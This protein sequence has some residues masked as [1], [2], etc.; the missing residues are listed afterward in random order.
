MAHRK[1]WVPFEEALHY[2]IN[3]LLQAHWLLTG[4]FCS[5]CCSSPHPFMFE[6]CYVCGEPLDDHTILSF[7]RK[8][9]NQKWSGKSQA[10]PCTFSVYLRMELKFT[11]RFMVA[12]LLCGGI[13]VVCEALWSWGQICVSKLRY[14]FLKGQWACYSVSARL[15]SGIP[16]ATFML[17]PILAQPSSQSGV[18][19]HVTVRI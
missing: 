8:R 12:V 5:V 14:K 18:R 11:L 2:Q 9:P 1:S 19:M 13:P 16:K 4:L 10:T 3:W 7:S 6:F 17:F 15:F